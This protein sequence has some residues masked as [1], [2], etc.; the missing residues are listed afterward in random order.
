MYIHVYKLDLLLYPNFLVVIPP[1]NS[2]MNSFM[3]FGVFR[4]PHESW[5]C[6]FHIF[7]SIN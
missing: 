5:C 2:K 7:H 1:N 6:D 3:K 4:H